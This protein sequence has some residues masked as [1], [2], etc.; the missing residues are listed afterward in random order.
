MHHFTTYLVVM[1]VALA[2]TCCAVISSTL[3][4]QTAFQKHSINS[5][6]LLSCDDTKIKSEISSLREDIYKH[7]VPELKELQQVN[8]SGL[9]MELVQL[10]EELKKIKNTILTSSIENCCSTTVSCSEI[11]EKYQNASS[12]KYWLFS[13]KW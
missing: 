4:N 5:P 8:V 1:L 11:F 7:L 6:L 2:T 3:C 12:G 9:T 10:Q 13:G